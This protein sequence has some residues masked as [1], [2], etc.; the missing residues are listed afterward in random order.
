MVPGMSPAML[1]QA[2]IEPRRLDRVQGM[3]HSMTSQERRN[4]QVIDGSR[5]RRIARGSGTSVQE[6]NLLLKQ[7]DSMK[8]MMR[9]ATANPK[10]ALRGLSGSRNTA[11]AL[12][13]PVRYGAKRRGR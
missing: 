1:S 3:V 6:V 2:Q 13:G 8:K 12:R 9:L 11:A 4:P 10:A 5:R 7:F